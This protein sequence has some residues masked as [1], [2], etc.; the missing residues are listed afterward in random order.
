MRTFLTGFD[1]NLECL[2]DWWL[3]NLRK[4]NPGCSVCVADFGMSPKMLNRI[5]EDSS[6]EFLGG[7][8]HP[9][10]AWF[11]KPASILKATEKFGRVCWMDVD[12]EVLKPIEDI[13]EFATEDKIG[14]T[15][16]HPSQHRRA[17]W[18]TGVVVTNGVIPLLKEWSEL[19]L[20][21]KHRGDQESFAAM[22]GKSQRFVNE[23]PQDYQWLRVSLVNG[24]DSPTKKVIH[25][26][27][28]RGKDHIIR[29]LI[30]K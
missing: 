9:V 25:W 22:V 10:K 1:S 16:D 18:A 14:L 26:S 17:Y 24:K 7:S 11:L 13:F 27:G 2:F 23:I 4:H 12:C 19:T 30:S 28:K 6:I 15:T 8:K 29:N 20:K 3:G 21:L 5:K